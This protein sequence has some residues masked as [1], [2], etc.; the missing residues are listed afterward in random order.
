MV[1]QM[2]LNENDKVTIYWTNANR[3]WSAHAIIKKV[4]RK[5]YVIQILHDVLSPDTNDIAY[6]KGRSFPMPSEEKWTA[7][8]R[9]A[10]GLLP[11]D[12]NINRTLIPSKAKPKK[13]KVR[14]SLYDKTT[15]EKARTLLQTNLQFPYVK[16]YISALGGQDNLSIYVAISKDDPSTW[17]NGIF[18]NSRSA[19]ILVDNTGVV[20]QISG[21]K[22]NLRKSTVKDISKAIEKINNIKVKGD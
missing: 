21:W 15:V 7:N 20:E 14:N 17:A 5:S 4:N 8:N 2:K 16:S 13:Q 10:L 19:K 1:T 6:S 22:L 12:K 11:L 18:E 9:I 3:N